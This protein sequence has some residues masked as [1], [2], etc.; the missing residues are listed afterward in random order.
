[1]IPGFL[2]PLRS[3]GSVPMRQLV[4]GSSLVLVLLAGRA[5]A[6]T[7]RVP[8]DFPD[9]QSAVTAAQDGD[10]ILVSKGQYDESVVVAGKSG[11]TLRGKGNP[12]LAAAADGP[13]L[14]V[15]ACTDISLV[16]LKVTGGQ[17]RAGHGI[18]VEST[19]GLLVSRCTCEFNAED[20]LLVESS[21]LVTIEKSRFLDN[22]DDGIDCF[23]STHCLVAKNVVERS[24]ERGIA[25]GSD[26]ALVLDA[27][28]TRNRVTDSGLEG[29][30][31]SS[32]KGVADRNRVD[33]SERAGIAVGDDK[34]FDLTDIVLSHNTVK[35]TVG[36]GMALYGTGNVAEDNKI[37]DSL[38][39]GINVDGDGPHTVTGNKIV[40]AE[41]G[42]A[43]R[44]G[45][46]GNTV[47]GN[48]VSSIDD[49]GYEV[50]SDGN[51]L[52]S[53]RSRSVGD[54]GFE[55][56]GTGNTFLSNSASKSGGFDAQDSAGGNTYESNKFKTVDGQVPN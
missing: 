40:R 4:T 18:H 33:G 13:T 45:T 23:E 20:G 56:S 11:L 12:V 42:I 29:I 30:R 26:S 28:V 48:R 3:S 50:G 52:E 16:G 1:M 25:V 38:V 32:H 19:T 53:N 51:V 24:D 55:I 41:D 36:D 6:D 21:D 54:N 22:G 7:L 39:S 34:V 44:T 49:D 43:L 47:T 35:N 27:L 8:Q 9:I 2:S 10:E 37:Q 31:I 15:S 46:G 14:F 17:G 5:S